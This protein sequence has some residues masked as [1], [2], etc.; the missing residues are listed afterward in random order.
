[1][2][3]KVRKLVDFSLDDIEKQGEAFAHLLNLALDV[4]ANVL[5]L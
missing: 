2:P 1:M 5:N 4:Y 3:N